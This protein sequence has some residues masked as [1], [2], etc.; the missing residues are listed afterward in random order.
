MMSILRYR[1]SL[2]LA[3]V[4]ALSVSLVRA[5]PESVDA[6]EAY[7]HGLVEDGAI[8]EA[9][10]QHIERLFS[11]THLSQLNGWLAAQ[12]LAGQL[13]SDTRLYLEALL[14]LAA[15]EASLAPVAANY[16]GNGNVTLL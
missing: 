10:H 13:G 7:L 16:T 6:I 4:L 14:G 1:S 5:H 11:L 9:Q 8:T 2:A 3:A 15:P 12:Q